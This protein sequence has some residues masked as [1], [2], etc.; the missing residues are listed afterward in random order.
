MADKELKKLNRREL[1]EMMLALSKEND[2]LREQ[3]AKAQGQLSERQ[4][5]IE[6]AGNIAEASLQLNQVFKS[7]QQAA[8]QYLENIRLLNFKQKEICQFREEESLRQSH[9]LLTE[10]KRKSKEMEQKTQEKCER[11]IHDAEKQAQQILDETYKKIEMI[12]KNDP[13]LKKLLDKYS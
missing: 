4:L 13:D 2:Q 11:M 9:A 8:D 6:K 5:R 7:A 1:L 3:L 10:T 12:I